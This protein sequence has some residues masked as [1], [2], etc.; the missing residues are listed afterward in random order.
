LPSRGNSLANSMETP[1]SGTNGEKRQRHDKT[2][3]LS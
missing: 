2:M 3:T 1:G